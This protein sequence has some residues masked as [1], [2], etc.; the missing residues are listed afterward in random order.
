MLN[1]SFKESVCDREIGDVCFPTE[2]LCEGQ[3]GLFPLSTDPTH[4]ILNEVV[5]HQ[6][7][8]QIYAP[9]ELSMKTQLLVPRRGVRR[10]DEGRAWLEAEDEGA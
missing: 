7:T 4:T 10:R 5:D 9:I 2:S 8:R 1:V 6:R 3:V